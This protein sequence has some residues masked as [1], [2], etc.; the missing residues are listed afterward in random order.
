MCN[1]VREFQTRRSAAQCSVG[2]SEAY[3]HVDAQCEG[4]M[5][6]QEEE[7]KV[8]LDAKCSAISEV[9]R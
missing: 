3:V 9:T 1:G 2:L 7:F 8:C 6:A 5:Y 4:A